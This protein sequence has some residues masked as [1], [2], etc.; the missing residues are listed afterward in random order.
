MD[1]SYNVLMSYE[2][3][4][5]YDFFTVEPILNN[6]ILVSYTLLAFTSFPC[7]INVYQKNKEQDKRT[8]VFPV[9]DHLFKTVIASYFF[10]VVGLCCYKIYAKLIDDR[11]S[12]ID[13]IIFFSIF[14]A[15][16]IIAILCEVNQILLSFLFIQRFILYFLPGSEK[17]I[18]FSEITMKKLIWSLYILLNIEGIIM[19]YDTYFDQIQTALK[20]YLNFY[21]ALN[22]LVL[23]SATLYI[24]IMFSI[25][26]FSHLASAQLNKPQKYILWQLIA[27]V[28][29][30]IILIPIIY[31]LVDAPFHEIVCYCKLTDAAMI[32]TLIQVSYLGCNRRNLQTMFVS[33]KP[34][35]ILKTLFCA[36]FPSSRVTSNE[37]YQLEPT[38]SSS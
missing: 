15:L 4:T 17:F 29:Q 14:V 25:Q 3:R 20:I 8:V 7:Y 24:P 9:I 13:T 36:C 11:S 23:A 26:K 10:V 12:V 2:N 16:A 30:K 1:F 34:K 18:D 31:F 21:I 28:T 6:Y 27:I 33:L 38:G 32:P 35:N 37:L 5:E 22:V 19:L